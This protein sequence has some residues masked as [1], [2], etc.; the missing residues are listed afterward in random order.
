MN[1]I[2]CDYAFLNINKVNEGG[3]LWDTH[4]MDYPVSTRKKKTARGGGAVRREMWEGN[5]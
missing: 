4:K 2:F 3:K 1:K 5:K